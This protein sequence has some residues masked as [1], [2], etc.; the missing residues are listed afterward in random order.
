MKLKEFDMKD[1]EILLYDKQ[2]KNQKNTL[3]LT[4]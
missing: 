3:K 4:R 1:F 2:S